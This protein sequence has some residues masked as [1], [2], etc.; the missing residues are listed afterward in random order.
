MSELEP[1]DSVTEQEGLEP[2]IAEVTANALHSDPDPDLVPVNSKGSPSRE[3]AESSSDS[4]TLQD[5]FNGNEINPATRGA[6]S[7][8]KRSKRPPAKP[9]SALLE[10]KLNAQKKRNSGKKDVAFVIKDHLQPVSMIL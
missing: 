5:G 3:V 7:A 6:T 4:A 8:N 1:K 2:H 9:S 10:A